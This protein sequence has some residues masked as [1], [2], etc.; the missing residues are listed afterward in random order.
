MAKKK[1]AGRTRVLDKRQAILDAALG[2]FAEQGFHGTSVPEIARAAGVAAGTI[3]RY[4]ESKD[5]VVNVLYRHWRGAVQT[6]VLEDFP[7]TGS[8]REQFGAY[9]RRLFD[10]ALEHPTAIAF[11]DFHHH[12]PYLDAQSNQVEQ[13]GRL[14]LRPF[15]EHAQKAGVLKRVPP[16][17][18]MAIAVGA[19]IGLVKSAREGNLEL[20]PE[21]VRSAEEVCWSGISAQK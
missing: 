7:F 16:E 8:A 5:A 3:Y 1:A 12:A 11:L 15:I 18:V 4:F 6:F 21:L 14:T 10:F 13:M 2:L 9:W 20:T 17:V 19:L